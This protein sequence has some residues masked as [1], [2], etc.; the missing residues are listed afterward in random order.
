M[1]GPPGSDTTWCGSGGWGAPARP[2]H[3][4]SPGCTCY[5][6]PGHIRDVCLHSWRGRISDGLSMCA[7]GFPSP[8]QGDCIQQGGL[9]QEPPGLR[10]AP[11]LA[12][13]APHLAAC[14]I[15]AIAVCKCLTAKPQGCRPSPVFWNT[16]PMATCRPL[17]H[18]SEVCKRASIE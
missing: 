12:S 1:V 18:P 10:A 5:L 14:M 15:P 16:S 9:F 2:R 17:V 11:D 3:G 7:L 13:G 8:P 6:K 4:F